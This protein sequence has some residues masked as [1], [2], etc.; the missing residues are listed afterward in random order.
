MGTKYTAIS[1]EISGNNLTLLSRSA[2][3]R[4]KIMPFKDVPRDPGPEDPH[5]TTMSDRV[6]TLTS[7]SGRNLHSLNHIFK[8]NL[9]FSSS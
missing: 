2:G 3:C 6:K 7:H 8:K 4:K 9:I 1:Q 5:P